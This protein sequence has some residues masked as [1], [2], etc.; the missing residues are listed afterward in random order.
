MEYNVF[1]YLIPSL[2]D[3][4][5]DGKVTAMDMSMVAKVMSGLITL[6]PAQFKRGDMNADGVLDLFDLVLIGQRVVGPP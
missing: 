5:G 6:T 1:S 4:T 3:I 2:G